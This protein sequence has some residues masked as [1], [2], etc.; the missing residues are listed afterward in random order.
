[1]LQALECGVVGSL[2]KLSLAYQKLCWLATTNFPRP[3]LECRLEVNMK[4]IH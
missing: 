1:M 4:L 3:T 2:I